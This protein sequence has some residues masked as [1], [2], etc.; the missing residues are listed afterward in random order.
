MCHFSKRVGLVHKL[1]QRIGSEERVDNA[2]YSLCINQVSRCEHFI[3]T[4]I[5]TLTNGTAHTC[6]TDGELIA[7]LLAHSAHTTV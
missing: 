2:G 4:H 3:V 5:H 1:A 6:Q 7:E